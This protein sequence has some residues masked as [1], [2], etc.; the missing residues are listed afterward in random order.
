[1]CEEGGTRRC[2]L[3][4]CV[5][6][7]LFCVRCSAIVQCAVCMLVC[8]QQAL[9]RLRA[10]GQSDKPAP[11]PHKQGSLG[12]V[13]PKLMSELLLLLD[14]PLG[15]FRLNELD[16]YCLVIHYV[17]GPNMMLAVGPP[18]LPLPLPP[19]A[20]KHTHSHHHHLLF[21][22]PTLSLLS[23]SA[24]LSLPRLEHALPCPAPVLHTPRRLDHPP[25]KRRCITNHIFATAP[26]NN[27]LP[28][29]CLPRPHHS[30]RRHAMQ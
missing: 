30:P 29:P 22:T 3:V 16:V 19:P 17:L 13:L 8:V 27:L 20:P 2:L 7:A 10:T 24:L 1:V 28:S 11:R 4:L 9:L 5:H 25:R 21:P 15:T 26:V 12:P 6:A 23:P 18:R 14:Q